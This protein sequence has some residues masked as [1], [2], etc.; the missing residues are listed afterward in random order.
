MYIHIPTPIVLGKCSVDVT[1]GVVS[2]IAGRKERV[3]R[4][5]QNRPACS[6][7]KV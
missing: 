7:L 2:F 3:F 4:K 5:A 6:S 1:E